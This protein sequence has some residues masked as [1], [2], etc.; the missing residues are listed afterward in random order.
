MDSSTPPPAQVRTCC[1]C[2]SI[3]VREHALPLQGELLTVCSPCYL[4]YELCTRVISGRAGRARTV[5]QTVILT[6]ALQNILE[7]VE[8]LAA[9]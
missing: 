8:T 9:A 2:Q 3:T 5:R 4:S 1:L 6:E 7:L